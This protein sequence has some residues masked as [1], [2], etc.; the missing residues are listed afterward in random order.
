[1]H[2]Y[3]FTERV[4][5]GLARARE[6]AF[7]MGHEY[8]GTEHLLLGI[9][10]DDD[11]VALAV[12]Q[13]L[14]ADC[15]AIRRRIQAVVKSGSAAHPA[16]DLPYTTRAKK[17]LE[18]AMAEAR[19]LNHT[20]VGTEHL[21]LGLI[22]EE[23]GIAANVLREAGLT[24]EN[25]RTET[26]RLLHGD[27]QPPA[28]E[29]LITPGPYETYARHRGNLDHGFTVASLN[30]APHREGGH[31]REIFRSGLRVYEGERDRSAVTTIYYLLDRQEISRWHVVQSDEV[32]HFYAGSTLFLLD[33]DPASGSL[34][35]LLLG[36]AA[37]PPT[38]VHVVPA[39]HWQAAVAS[40]GVSLMGCTV[41]PGFEFSDFQMVRNVAGHEAAF[42]GV[43]KGF[44]QLL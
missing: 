33:Y 14:N 9:V 42:Q 5:K 4:R 19:E 24:L 41:A 27:T 7:H 3:N 21:L 20:Y 35:Q 44:V 16:G 10:S 28:G 2:G 23:Q 25:T 39:G 22:R 17:T 15:D 38:F 11:G 18:F 30:L 31:Y 36:S 26:L 29:K 8:V 6:E 13:N 37:V 40:M 12:I 34:K 43:M 32:W 1:M